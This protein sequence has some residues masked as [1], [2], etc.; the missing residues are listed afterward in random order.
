VTVTTRPNGRAKLQITRRSFLKRG[1]TAG[2]LGTL[3]LQA[4]TT[5]AGALERWGLPS[6]WFRQ[7]TIAPV[8]QRM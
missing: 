2:A 1:L 3:A 8:A 4:R 6:A 7:G 5:A